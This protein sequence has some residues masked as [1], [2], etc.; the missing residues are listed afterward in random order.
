M[1]ARRCTGPSTVLWP[2][3]ARR[4]RR[5]RARTGGRF[6]FSSDTL[7]DCYPLSGEIHDDAVHLDILIVDSEKQGNAAITR[8]RI[9]RSSRDD[10]KPLD[11]RRIL[12]GERGWA[13]RDSKRRHPVA[14]QS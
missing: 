11:A 13:G 2:S 3:K 8:A 14:E 6:C 9:R 10:T 5:A 12:V 4:M 1:T 7:P